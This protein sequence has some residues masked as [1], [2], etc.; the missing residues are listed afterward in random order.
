MSTEILYNG[1][2]LF[3]GVA[4]TPFVGRT[5]EPIRYGSIWGTLEVFSLEGQIT[6]LCTD[7]LSEIIEKSEIILSGLSSTQFGELNIIDNGTPVVTKPYVKV[8]SFNLEEDVTVGVKPF[9]IELEAYEEDFFSGYYGVID[10]A[11]NISYE[12][13]QDG[14]ILINRSCSARGFNTSSSALQNAVNYVQSTISTVLPVS[15]ILIE[16]NGTITSPVLTSISEEINRLEASYS[17]T[18][19]YAANAKGPN[20]G[21]I[22]EI[23]YD[24]SYSETGGVYQISAN[25]SLT[26][27]V[28]STITDLRSA[29]TKVKLYEL[30]RQAMIKYN[31]LDINPNPLGLNVN[32]NIQESRLDFSTSF[33]T[34]VLASDIDFNYEV[35]IDLSD[36]ADLSSVSFNGTIKSRLG[37]NIRWSKMKDFYQTL[38]VFGICQAAL[39]EELPGR[40]LTT[41]PSSYSSEF[42]ER[43]GEIR[44]SASFSEIHE[45][46]KWP[47]LF[48][49]FDYSLAFT[50]GLKIKNKVQTINGGS[51]VFDIN[52]VSRSS[53]AISG[54]AAV[55]NECSIDSIISDI[56]ELM[57]SLLSDYGIVDYF[58]ESISVTESKEKK[59][60]Y[61]DFEMTVSYNEIEEDLFLGG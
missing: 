60:P 40:N 26:A 42:D 14:D 13:S 50:P 22:F 12:E 45:K 1:I 4:S 31:G 9:Q 11:N 32:E 59:S 29:F 54:T 51:K 17:L 3:S 49:S 5:L 25:G 46:N 58:V 27:G 30:C 16:K 6:G 39:Q 19:K 20:S 28:S 61:Y 36:L 7:G 41:K 35:S 23:S 33:N 18:K 56:K 24:I 43:N 53:C 55:L 10:P 2:N 47:H 8:R 52:S 44:I 21:F 37:Q 34:D 38:D 57:I 48:R 15:S